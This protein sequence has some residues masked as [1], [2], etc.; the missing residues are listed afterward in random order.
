MDKVL[1][2][3][4]TVVS[5]EEHQ[6]AI[7][8]GLQRGLKYITNDA[9]VKQP[10][11]LT[12]ENIIEINDNYCE[13]LY[14]LCYCFLVMNDCALV[15]A[16]RVDG[17]CAISEEEAKAYF[18]EADELLAEAL[19]MLDPNE[20]EPQYMS[21]SRGKIC[22]APNTIRPNHYTE[23]SDSMAI[24]G[25][26]YILHHEFGHF[27]YAHDEDTPFNELEADKYAI[28]QLKKWG[29]ETKSENTI[30]AGIILAL[31]STAF[32]NPS[33]TSTCYPDIDARI[34]YA[35]QFA[36]SSLIE[37]PNSLLYRIIS[38]SALIWANYF[39]IEIPAITSDE[40]YKD[41]CCRIKRSLVS[42]KKKN[43]IV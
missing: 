6:K 41:Y 32:I 26:T 12:G 22:R 36:D 11:S 43:K 39:K 37:N 28:I 3:F 21:A 13:F 16:N 40:T 15:I 14:L 34:E 10:A 29:A 2:L 7:D 35:L 31:V 23:Y 5:E 19:K 27:I 30:F 18:L 20:K 24:A 17:E 42:H 1:S 33:L 25:L 38:F 8:E 4:Q 9:P